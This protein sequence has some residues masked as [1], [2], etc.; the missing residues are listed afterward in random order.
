M[1]LRMFLFIYSK[2]R[3]IAE[4]KMQRGNEKARQRNEGDGAYDRGWPYGES[5][6]PRPGSTRNPRMTFFR[7]RNSNRIW[8]MFCY[9]ALFFWSEGKKRNEIRRR[10]KVAVRLWRGM[11]LYL[12]GPTFCANCNDFFNFLFF[13][14]FPS[15]FLNY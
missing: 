15:I 9:F 4:C 12:W 2:H 6:T 5:C 1:L 3:V 13:L 7:R 14:F 8:K 11:S 10:L